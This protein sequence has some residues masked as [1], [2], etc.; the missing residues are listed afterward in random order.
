MIERYI[1]AVTRELPEKSRKD[2]AEELR[3]LINYR[4]EKVDKTLPEEERIEKVLRQLGD[5]RKLADRF[6]GRE[7][8][9]IGPRYYYKYLFV[10]KVVVLSIIIGISVVSGLA[11]L[12]STESFTEVISGYLVTLFSAVLQGVV[13]VTGIF[14]LLEYNDVSVEPGKEQEEWDPSKLPSLPKGK[15]RISRVESVFSIVFTTLFLLLFFFLRDRIGIYYSSGG[16]YSFIPLLDVEAVSLFEFLIFF[17]FI[18]NI[19]VE[20]IKLI[21]GR[22]TITVAGLTS[23][24]NIISAAVSIYIIYYM[25][26]WDSQFIERFEDFMPLSFERTLIFTVVIIIIVTLIEALASLYKGIRYSR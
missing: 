13:W 23:I 16:E 8:Y 21:K 25:D 9:L 7:R 1:Y 18:L 2:T 6:R 10:L 24:L 15:A 22:W 4:L 5:P 19:T 3:V 17:I 20:L 12:F 26:I 11:V 14:V